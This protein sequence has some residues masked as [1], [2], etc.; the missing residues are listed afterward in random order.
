MRELQAHDNPICR[1]WG[2]WSQI[3]NRRCGRLNDRTGMCDWRH[4]TSLAKTAKFL[5]NAA[6][7]H[8]PRM[9]W[10]TQLV[11]RSLNTASRYIGTSLPGH[12]GTARWGEMEAYFYLRSLGYRIVARNFRS[13]R[14]HGEIDI[15][16]WD[17]AVLCF[18][19][20]K[21]HSQ[22]GLVP[23]EVAV[24]ASKRSHVRSV[25]RRYIR[26]L[27]LEGPPSCRFDVVSVVLGDGH[28]GHQIRL[29]KGA[30][31]WTM[32]YASTAERDVKPVRRKG[33]KR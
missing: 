18:I 9:I 21:T 15:I 33:W 19:E 29:H 30:F 25:A 16:G 22:P 13:A 24:D 32:K 8:E 5:A 7:I 26:Q 3:G 27:Q 20:V 11:A 2:Q 10:L 28:R 17:D 12:L 23:P 4:G 6:V 1:F 14:D 31:G